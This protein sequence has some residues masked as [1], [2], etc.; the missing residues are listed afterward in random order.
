MLHYVRNQFVLGATCLPNKLEDKFVIMP[1]W[2]KCCLDKRHSLQFLNC[3][4]ISSQLVVGKLVAVN[5][6]Q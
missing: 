1:D 4:R 2:K 5:S 6:L 3:C